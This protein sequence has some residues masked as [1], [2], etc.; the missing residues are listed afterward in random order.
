MK[1]LPT[2]NE[3]QC[4]RMLKQGVNKNFVER[5][6]RNNNIDFDED[7]KDQYEQEDKNDY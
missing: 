1:D 2:T 3:E 6:A 4:L 5:I 7:T